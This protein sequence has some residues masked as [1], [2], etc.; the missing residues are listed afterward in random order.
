VVASLS[1]HQSKKTTTNSYPY[2]TLGV[3][4]GKCSEMLINGALVGG[5]P[6]G[7]G[8][9]FGKKSKYRPTSIFVLELN[10]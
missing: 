6:P 5:C 2:P 7:V 4:G 10:E 1:F 8:V 3:V 9:G